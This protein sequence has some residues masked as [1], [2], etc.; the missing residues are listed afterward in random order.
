MS[1]VPGR[2]TLKHGM[3]V[4]RF[5]GSFTLPTSCFLGFTV[6]QYQAIDVR[7]TA[8]QEYKCSRSYDTRVE[9]TVM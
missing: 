6:D 8:F 5:C 1:G 7:V 9:H 2:P 4:I 3:Y